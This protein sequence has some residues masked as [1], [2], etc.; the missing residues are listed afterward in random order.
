MPIAQRFGAEQYIADLS[1]P[2]ET[3]RLAAEVAARHDRLDVLVDNAG[4]VL[5]LERH[6]P[7]HVSRRDTSSGRR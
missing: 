4:G 2:A 3:L 7:E 1:A 5:H 6:H